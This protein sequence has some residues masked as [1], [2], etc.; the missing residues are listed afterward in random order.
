MQEKT[1]GISQLGEEESFAA[2]N[3]PFHHSTH[4]VKRSIPQGC[5]ACV[6]AC[7]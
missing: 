3:K 6:R 4:Y 1:I 2:G 5:G 7:L